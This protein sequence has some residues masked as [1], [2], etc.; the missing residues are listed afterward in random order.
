MDKINFNRMN[1][2]DRNNTIT[3]LHHLLFSTFNDVFTI[4][5]SSDYKVVMKQVVFGKCDYYEIHYILND[6][7][8]RPFK[9]YH[10][11]TGRSNNMIFECEAPDVLIDAL[12]IH[13]KT[14]A[15]CNNFKRVRD[16]DETYNQEIDVD[17][18]EKYYRT[19]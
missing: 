3:L 10:I 6:L 12:D 17:R 7:S 16:E 1:L 15:P 18:W 9:L 14:K 2:H 11:I 4:S 5:E 13:I 8:N 19:D